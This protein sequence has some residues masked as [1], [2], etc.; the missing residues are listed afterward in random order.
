MKIILKNK[1]KKPTTFRRSGEGRS[2]GDTSPGIFLW[3]NPQKE[4]RQTAP[5]GFWWLVRSDEA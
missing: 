1:F 3:V 4:V 5:R 2:L